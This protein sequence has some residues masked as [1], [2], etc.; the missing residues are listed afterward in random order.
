MSSVRQ[1]ILDAIEA[2]LKLIVAGK[3][4]TLPDGSTR[5]SATTVKGVYPWRK[6][7][8]TPTLLPAIGIWD[9]E[10][11][12]G[13]ATLDGGCHLLQV[14]VVGFVVGSAAVDSARELSADI[15][16]AIGSDTTFGG[17]VEISTFDRVPLDMEQAG[18]VVSAGEIIVTA[19]YRTNSKWLI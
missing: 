18:D 13:D 14:S 19:T 15:L 7:P 1:Q 12:P 11:T 5:T 9:T 17:L 16:A 2:R 3:V 8:F 10:S 4:W 6:V